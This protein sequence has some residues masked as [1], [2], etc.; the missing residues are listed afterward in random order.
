ME[1]SPARQIAGTESILQQFLQ[2][3]W[4]GRVYPE[5][6]LYCLIAL[7]RRDHKTRFSTCTESFRHCLANTATICEDQPGS[8]LGTINRAP[9]MHQ[10]VL[11]LR[12]SA[13]PPFKLVEAIAQVGLGRTFC[14][15]AKSHQAKAQDFRCYLPRL[16][17]H[18]NI[19]LQRFLT[20]CC[21]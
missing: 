20:Q 4:V 18:A 12:R 17:K 7:S 10:V 2:V 15:M 8:W 14:V 1:N 16:I 13:G 5:M 6:T 21:T 11:C 9:T 19:S 3:C